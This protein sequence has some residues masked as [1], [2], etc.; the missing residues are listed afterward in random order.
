[1]FHSIME[2]VKGMPIGLVH[3]VTAKKLVQLHY[4]QKIHVFNHLQSEIVLRIRNVSILTHMKDVVKHLFTRDVEETQTILCWSMIVGIN[5]NEVMFLNQLLHNLVILTLVSNKYKTLWYNMNFLQTFST[6]LAHCFQTPTDSSACYGADP[7][8]TQVKWFYDSGDGVCKQ[9]RWYSDCDAHQR[10]L[11]RF[12]NRQECEDRCEQAQ[13]MH[14]FLCDKN[15]F[16]Q[17]SMYILYFY[18]V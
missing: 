2:D 5:V 8:N 1:M 15:N 13:G 10:S 7:T 16:K 9:F 12:D 4:W 18:F 14:T 6:T 17:N 11:N 3:W